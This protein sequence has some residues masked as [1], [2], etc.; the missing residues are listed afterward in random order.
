MN[1]PK[2]TC[3]S[4][5]LSDQIP[6]H[7]AGLDYIF[8]NWGVLNREQRIRLTEQVAEIDFDRIRAL[9][10]ATDGPTSEVADLG[11][12]SAPGRLIPRDIRR[13][14]P[15]E[16]ATAREIGWQ[17][18]RE[19]RVAII[20]VAGGEGSRL[21]FPH[22]KGQ[23]PIGPVSGKSLYQ[24]LVEQALAMSRRSGKVIP[25]YVMTSDSTHE[26]TMAFFRVH[27][28]FGYDAA[29]LHFFSQGKMPA[30]DQR[31]GNVIMSAH[32]RIAFAPDGHGGLLNA[33]R[34]ARLF[35]DLRSRNI[36]TIFYHQVDNP[37][38][39]VCDPAFLGFHQIHRAEVSTK[40][41]SKEEPD[42]KVGLL[43]E[44]EDRHRIIEYSDLPADLAAQ[45]DA[46]GQLKLRCG[47]IAVH[48]F[49]VDFLERM[50]EQDLPFHRSSK[51]VAFV[52]DSGEVVQSTENN[53]F[54]FEKFI[55][56][57]L[58]HAQRPVAMEV[59]REHEFVP[60]KNSHG[61]HSPDHVRQSLM[62]L[63]TRWMQQAGWTTEE[64]LPVE[65]PASVAL[66]ETDFIAHCGQT[67]R[68]N[69]PPAE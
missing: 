61:D 57:I 47:N 40:V 8:R 69:P 30:V 13:D 50:A 18:L 6:P 59:V 64:S 41:V 55:F 37:L 39:R 28:F 26:E 33:M 60:L 5:E 45:R 23:F 14:N 24:M 44:M 17:A 54:K 12:A 46:S 51:S 67:S 19:G 11:K 20:L 15:G 52:N 22:P 35:D 65:I 53:A 42:E 32:D 43:V 66:D 31:T 1:E 27:S 62:R 38:V 4:P 36:E 29:N 25:Y 2:T 58:P 48:L 9:H 49:N 63:H 68:S 10:Q 34:T 56:D 7:P 3:A 16:F 21:G